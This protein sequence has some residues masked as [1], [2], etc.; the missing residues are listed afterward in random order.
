[1]SDT[2]EETPIVRIKGVWKLFG[3]A[4]GSVI[5]RKDRFGDGNDILSADKDTIQAE[6][7][8]VLALRDVN[9]EIRKGEFY[10]IMGLSGSGKSTLIRVLERLIEPTAG[11]LY[12]HE[13]DV[14]SYSK[15]RLNEF[16]KHTVSM[17][18]QHFGLLPHYTVL[19][20]AAYGLKARGEEKAA[21]E[22][23]AREVLKTVGLEGWE[24]YYPS[25]LSGGM[26][27]RVGIARALATEPEILLMDEPFSGLDPLIRRQMQDELVDLQDTLH[28]TIIFVTHDLHEALKLGDRIAIMRNGM[29][30]QIG[31]PEEIVSE[32]ADDYV[33]EF[34]QD[35][36]PARVFSASSI[37]E[38]PKAIVYSWQGPGVAKRIMIDGDR[39]WAFVIGHNRKLLGI[40]HLDDVEKH[41]K[42][43]GQ[44]LHEFI[45]DVAVTCDPDTIVEDLFPL[46]S[47]SSYAV[48]VVDEQGRFLGAVRPRRIFEVMS[49]NGEEVNNV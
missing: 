13:E 49:K 7:G 39:D 38:E 25:A 2:A 3:P 14:L 23:K 8:H 19:Q 29:V 1:M 32:P 48:A 42:S 10:V 5:E 12:V 9:L 45:R 31:S 20:N 6:T 27:Q 21:R 24:D 37:M 43:K 11:H 4:P 41:S 40:V 17:V 33:R 47:S 36:S 16:R 15:E 30:I 22:E 26:Q 46:V 35:A 18:F 28:K 44:G 34:V